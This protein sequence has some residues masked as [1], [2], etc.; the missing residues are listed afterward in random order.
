MVLHSRI[1]SDIGGQSRN[2]SDMLG[3]SRPW[4]DIVGQPN[5]DGQVELGLPESTLVGHIRTLSDI[6]AD[7]RPWSDMVGKSRTSSPMGGYS[8]PLSH[9]FELGLTWSDTSDLG[10]TVELGRRQST[11]VGHRRTVLTFV[12]HGR[13]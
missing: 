5:L 9:S 1:W 7:S 12:A 10:Q 2:W 13:T 11:L 8:R 4:S 6:V 3:Q